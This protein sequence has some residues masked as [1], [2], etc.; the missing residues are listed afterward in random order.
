MQKTSLL[1]F[2]YHLCYSMDE[3]GIAEVLRPTIL[4]DHQAIAG[5]Q[6]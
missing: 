1:Q 4:L 5:H 2:D 6:D 3:P